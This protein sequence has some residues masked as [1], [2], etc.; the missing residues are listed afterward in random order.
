ML[1]QHSAALAALLRWPS[2]EGTF[3][4]DM[5]LPEFKKVRALPGFHEL[6]RRMGLDDYWRAHGPPEP[7]CNLLLVNAGT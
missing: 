4:D 7:I 3:I 6:I 2:H 1:G 5:W